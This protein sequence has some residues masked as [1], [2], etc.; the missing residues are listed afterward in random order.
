MLIHFAGVNT[1]FADNSTAI[2]ADK[3]FHMRQLGLAAAVAGETVY[4]NR[5]CVIHVGLLSV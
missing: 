2:G 1:G 4:A 5:S 3:Y